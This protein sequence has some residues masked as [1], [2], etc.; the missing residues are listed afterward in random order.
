[1]REKEAEMNL[2]LVRSFGIAEVLP[3]NPEAR[4]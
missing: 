4:S 3:D 2:G 1:M